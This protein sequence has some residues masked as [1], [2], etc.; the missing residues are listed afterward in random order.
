[1][2]SNKRYQIFMNEMYES[3]DK[4]RLLKRS[5]NRTLNFSTNRMHDHQ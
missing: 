5:L 2:I 3:T 1:M 4:S